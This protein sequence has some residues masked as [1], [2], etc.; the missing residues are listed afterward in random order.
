VSTFDTGV[1]IGRPIEDVFALVS[2][3]LQFPR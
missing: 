1:R 3:P 2:D